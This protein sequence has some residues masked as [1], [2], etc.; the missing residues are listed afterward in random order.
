LR[1]IGADSL[2]NLRRYFELK[3]HVGVGEGD[4]HPPMLP[5]PTTGGSKTRNLGF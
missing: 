1:R 2:D 4:E 5:E 3:V